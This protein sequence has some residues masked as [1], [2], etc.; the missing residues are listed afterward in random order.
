MGSEEGESLINNEEIDDGDKSSVAP[1]KST[2]DGQKSEPDDKSL[3]Q[4]VSKR[5][6]GKVTEIPLFER[7][8]WLLHLHF[9][10]KEYPICKALINEILTESGEV[11]EYA[12][13]IKALILREE[14]EIQESLDAFQ[15]CVHINQSNVV[16]LKQVARSLFLLGRHK[17]AL[18]VYIEALKVNPNDWEVFHNQG[19]CYT[20]TKD[21]KLAKECF[22]KALQLSKH[23]ITFKMLGK[24]YLNEGNVNEAISTFKKAVEFSPENSELMTTLGLLYMQLNQNQKA[25]EMFGNA[26]VYDP[27]NIKAILAVGAMIQDQGDFEVALTK[28]HSA[29]TKI[30]E[31]PQLWN[32]IGMCFFGKGKYV[33][34]ISCLKRA[35]YLA[36]FEWTIMYN[37]GLVHITMHQYASAFHYLTAAITIKPKFSKLYMLLAVTLTHLNAH[38]NAKQA[39][40][41]ALK[42]NTND[43]EINLNYAVF[44]CNR[45]EIH[46]AQKHLAEYKEKAK[47]ASDSVKKG[48]VD[49]ETQQ[50]VNQL[51][52]K[53]LTGTLHRETAE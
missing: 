26:L 22:L 20:Y 47:A 1:S 32:N 15:Q 16:N 41:Q 31:S 44:L 42:C 21:F 6:P 27:A 7:R 46:G 9:V 25:F 18:Q 33:A 19:V 11:C 51:E 48:K 5:R 23:D 24:C 53:L 8:N 30:P 28:Y 35:V 50:V 10:R 17:A 49:E 36:P 43:P 2:N 38:D 52:A 3:E 4:K 12:M 45:N 37:L 34:A 40:D 29:S 39:Y 13:Y 14:G